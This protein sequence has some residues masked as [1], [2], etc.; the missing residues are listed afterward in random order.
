MNPLLKGCE[1]HFDFLNFFASLFSRNMDSLSIPLP[2][3]SENVSDAEIAYWKERVK[4]GLD[5]E[6]F[7]HGMEMFPDFHVKGKRSPNEVYSFF[8]DDNGKIDDTSILIYD[9]DLFDS[10]ISKKV[11]YCT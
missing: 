5:A 1:I 10:I 2:I 9:E 6:R 8:I 4:N 7:P 11:S 3:P